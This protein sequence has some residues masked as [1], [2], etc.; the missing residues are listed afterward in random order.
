MYLN[1]GSVQLSLLELRIVCMHGEFFL[2]YAVPRCWRIRLAVG[3]APLLKKQLCTATCLVLL[4]NANNSR[5]LTTT[6]FEL[7]RSNI[8][9][10]CN[11]GT[12]VA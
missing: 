7:S 5:T 2:S 10:D 12:A 1:S 3:C 9:C 8:S 11:A 6:I 4:D